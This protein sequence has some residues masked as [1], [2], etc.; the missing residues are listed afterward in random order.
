MDELEL[1]KEDHEFQ[2]KLQEQQ[3]AHENEL[4][5]KEL[6]W[7]GKFFGSSDN[8]AKNIAFTVII[9]LIVGVTFVSILA[10]LQDMPDR[11]LISKVWNMVIPVITLSLGYIFG[12]KE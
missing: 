7:L 8:G 9:L 2:L 6:G 5:Q 12:K 11:D 1:Q 4:R 10:Y 3:H